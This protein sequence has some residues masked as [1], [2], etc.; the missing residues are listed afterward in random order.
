MKNAKTLT[1]LVPIGY[2][3]V[4]QVQGDL[5]KDNQDEFVL[6]IKGTDSH[7]IIHHEYRGELDRN[8]RGIII[9][10]KKMNDTR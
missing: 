2:V 1:D 10:N 8:R 6:I 4:N 7:K 3:V 9:A 5:N